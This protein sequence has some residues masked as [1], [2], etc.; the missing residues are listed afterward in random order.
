MIHWAK[1]NSKDAIASLIINAP[2]VN[3]LNG[4]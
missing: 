4:H 2:Y 3:S 1:A